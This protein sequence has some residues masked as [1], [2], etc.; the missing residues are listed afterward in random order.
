MSESSPPEPGSSDAHDAGLVGHELKETLASADACMDRLQRILVSDA[1]ALRELT[2]LRRV[3]A[4]A[5]HLVT[6]LLEG[7]RKAPER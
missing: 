5:D 7:R 1:A 4:Q 3:L 2:H 6:A